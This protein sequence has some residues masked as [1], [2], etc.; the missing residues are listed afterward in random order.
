MSHANSSGVIV[1]AMEIQPRV[2]GIEVI[3]IGLI[4]RSD[5]G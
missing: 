2:L 5:F 1:L 3:C 4:L